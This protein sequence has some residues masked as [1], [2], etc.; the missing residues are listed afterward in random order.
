ILGAVALKKTHPEPVADGAAAPTDPAAAAASG[1]P[2]S[3]AVAEVP[4]AP[5]QPTPAAALAAPEPESATGTPGALAAADEP[6]DGTSAHKKHLHV[7]PFGNGPVHHGNVLHLKLDGPIES[8]EGAQQPTGFE[9]KI[10]GRKAAEAA[11]PLAARDSRIAAIKVSNAA[12]GAD[13][14]VAFKDGVP[15]Y[16]V[17][18]HGDTL[19]IALAPVGAIDK[20]ASKDAKG[21]KSDKGEKAEKPS[22]H[23]HEKADKK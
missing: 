12:A 14:T 11:A 10:P 21:E 13:L 1:A 23:H 20:V 19:V 22:K 3:S 16:Q 18:A 9:V 7:A 5:A 8:I 17:S 15:N 6:L 4:V 2:A